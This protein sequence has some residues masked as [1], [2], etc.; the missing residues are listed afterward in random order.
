MA[1]ILFV[2][3]DARSP[4][5]L[6]TSS[7]EHV[8]CTLFLVRGKLQS[9][10]PSILVQPVD[11]SPQANE[12]SFSRLELLRRSPALPAL[13]CFSAGDVAR[14]RLGPAIPAL[15]CLSAGGV[16]HTLSRPSYSSPSVLQRK[17]CNANLLSALSFQPWRRKSM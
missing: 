3:R 4:F 10:L 9:I 15:L 13:P 17:C 5:G 7:S 12:E 14:T 6:R 2:L 11:C 1:Y 8:L 16:A